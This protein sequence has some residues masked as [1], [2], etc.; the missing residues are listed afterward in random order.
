MFFSLVN[1]STH[2]HNWTRKYQEVLKWITWVTKHI[3]PCPLCLTVALTS[4]NDKVTY[5]NQDGD[6]SFTTSCFAW[7]AQSSQGTAVPKVQWNFCSY[8]GGIVHPL[9]NRASHPAVMKNWG[10]YKHK[11]PKWATGHNGKCC[12]TNLHVLITRSMHSTK[13]IY[14]IL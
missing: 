14:R 11:F 13:Y 10:K 6:F 4:P 12:H 2:C 9:E 5:P 1:L 8:P 3:L 7:Q